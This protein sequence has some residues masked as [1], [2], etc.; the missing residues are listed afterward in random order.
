MVQLRVK[1][2]DGNWGGWT[3]LEADDVEQNAS[4]GAD[5][6]EARGGTAPLWTGEAYGIEVIVQGCRRRGARRRQ[7]SR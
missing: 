4:P 7:R 6:S 1:D 3:T 5:G 2:A